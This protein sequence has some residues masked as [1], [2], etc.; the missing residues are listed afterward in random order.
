MIIK[1]SVIRRLLGALLLGLLAAGPG[2][3][4]SPAHAAGN[5]CALNSIAAAMGV[6]ASEIPAAERRQ[7]VSWCKQERQKEQR[8]VARGPQALSSGDD[9]GSAARGPT[10][11]A[12]ANTD[13]AIWCGKNNCVCWKGKKYDGCHHTDKLCSTPLKCVGRICGCTATE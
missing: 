2:L 5:D 11:L 1:P 10:D 4:A 13:T 9:G 7:L 6:K 12:G 8:A 3:L